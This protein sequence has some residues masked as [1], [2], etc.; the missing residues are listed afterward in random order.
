MIKNWIQSLLT[1]FGFNIINLKNS[2]SNLDQYFNKIIELTDPLIFDVGA[3]VGQSIEV[4]RKFLSNPK[5]HCFEPDKNAFEI[6]EKKYSNDKNIKLN[7][8]GLGDKKDFKNFNTYLASGKSSF[9]KLNTNTEYIK[10]RSAVRNVSPKDY[11][12]DS[13]KQSIETLDDYCNSNN[14]NHID[15]LKIDTQGYDDKVIEGAAGMIN[16]NNIDLIKVEIIFSS[17]YDREIFNIYN[18]EKILIPANYK[19]FGISTN[20]NLLTDQLWQSD[21]VYISNSLYQKIKKNEIFKSFNRS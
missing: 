14:I 19:I 18:I 15:I 4:Y 6:L 2:K 17:V 20:G 8:F 1:Y 10:Y 9:V 7:S 11:F 13:Y 12:I 3:N 16:K 5:F 21:F